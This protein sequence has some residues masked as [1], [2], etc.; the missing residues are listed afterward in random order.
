MTAQSEL[1]KATALKL[2][3]LYND[4][5]CHAQLVSASGISYLG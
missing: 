5:P 2:Q 3:Q 1:L 4:F